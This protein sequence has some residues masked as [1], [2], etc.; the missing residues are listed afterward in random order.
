[1][2]LTG[3][4]PATV[5][6]YLRHGLLPQPR[7][8][9]PNRFAYDDRHV[10]ALRLVRSLR[11]ERDLPL[12]LIRRIMPE[13]LRLEA[14]EAFRPEMWDRALAPRMSRRRG[15]STRLLEAAKEAFARR[16]YAEV[17]VDDLCRAAR[18]A[19][20]SF[21]RHFRSKEDLLLAAAE[22]LAG[23]LR[24]RLA[25]RLGPEATPARAAA[26]LAE[27]LEPVLPVFLEVF[28]RAVQGR[29]GYRESVARVFG[30]VAGAVGAATSGEGRPEERGRS[31]LGA[32]LSLILVRIAGGGAPPVARQAG[33]GGAAVELAPGG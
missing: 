29:P 33:A 23:D 12:P 10:H 4:P 7:R 9:A 6:Y 20:G 14:E 3:V 1:M 11:R 31:A 13:L 18:I 24:A 15:P 5:H 16:G 8:L 30:T 22:S 28:A 32:A 21:Y 26:Q 27:L 17:N 2:A 19:K 25:E